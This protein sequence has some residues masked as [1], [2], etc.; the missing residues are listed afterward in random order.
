M[1]VLCAMCNS[2]PHHYIKKIWNLKLFP[3]FSCW[4]EEG[5]L[6]INGS[7]KLFTL[8]LLAWSNSRSVASSSLHSYHFYIIIR[9]LKK[10][11]SSF[12]FILKKKKKKGK[13][14]ENI[15]SACVCHPIISVTI[16]NTGRGSPKENEQKREN[17]RLTKHKIFL[18]CHTKTLLHVPIY[19]EKE[20]ENNRWHHQL[21]A[22]RAK[23]TL[24]LFV[25][26]HT[27]HSYVR[28]GRLFLASYQPVEFDLVQQTFFVLK[29]T[30]R[31]G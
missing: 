8:S 10:R 28:V 27:S 3:A 2:R 5:N 15:K 24:G 30:D 19:I 22:H 20:R 9:R 7:H 29:K 11:G 31:D 23:G 25:S 4:G 17:E 26:K 1:S 21:N 12:V 16:W 6:L 13:K 18:T 14:K